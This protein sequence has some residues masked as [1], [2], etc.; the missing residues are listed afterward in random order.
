MSPFSAVNG[1]ASS[2]V[3]APSIVGVVGVSASASKPYN[4]PNAG[5]TNLLGS[6]RVPLGGR[7]SD[8]NVIPIK[9]SQLYQ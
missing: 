4:S 6:S 9:E 7:A 2:V 3:N 8:V 1:S 5:R